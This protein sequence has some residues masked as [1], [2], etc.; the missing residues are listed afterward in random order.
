MGR[1]LGVGVQRVAV[2]RQAV[3]QGLVGAG[4]VG[5]L[6]VRV[7]LGRRELARRAP[8]AAPA[9]FARR[10]MLVR[11]VNS[12]WPSDTRSADVSITTTAPEPL[13]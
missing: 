2:A 1:E 13:S 7:P 4:L 10:N 11:V 5:D 12:G 3:E 8:L 9:P 6:V